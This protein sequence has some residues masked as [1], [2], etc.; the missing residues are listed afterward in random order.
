M[1]GKCFEWIQYSKTAMTV[2]LKT[3]MKEDFRTASENG[4]NVGI[5]RLKQRRLEED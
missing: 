1:K 2:Q 4:K 3:L 5:M